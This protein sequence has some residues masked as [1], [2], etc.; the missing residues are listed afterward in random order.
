[1]KHFEAGRKRRVIYNDDSDQQYA[2]F[3]NHSIVDQQSFLNARTTPVFNTHV[4]TYVWC[5]GNG[6]DPP[7]RGEKVK[8]FLRTADDAT[9]VIVDSCREHGLE[10]WGS[11][12]MNDIHD[13]FSSDS[14]ENTND[15]LKAQ[16][17]EYLIAP[18]SA[19]DLPEELTE[20]S[21][22]TAFN[23]ARPEVRQYRLDFIERN[24]AAHDF[25]GY[26]LDFQRMPWFFPLGEERLHAGEMTELVREARSRLDA[27]GK[28]RG[29]AYTLVAHVMDS[30]ATSLEVGLD[31]ETWVS[32]GLLDVLVVGMGYLPYSV[33]LDQWLELGREYRVPVYPCVNTNTYGSWYRDVFKRNEAWHEAIRASSDYYLHRGADGLYIFNLFC[34]AEEEGGRLQ[35]SFVYA[36]LREIGELGTLARK[37]KLYSI[38][39]ITAGGWYYGCERGPLPIALDT[40]EHPL[41]LQM[42]S[43]A[44][45]PDARFTVL[46]QAT[47]PREG[48][49]VW[50]R[51]NHR[52]LPQPASDGPWYR[53]EV[54]SGVMR[55][56]HN[57]LSVWTDAELRSTDNPNI[58]HAVFV[59]TEYP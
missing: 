8:T 47:G 37:D 19:L 24:A 5:V 39:P 6:S 22:W 23:F 14:L 15:P 10:V 4:D 45:D 46:I 32:E 52:L 29:R 53:V 16:H 9:D 50:A 20:R 41:P 13:W 57:E 40:V 51:L 49:R 43:D 42:G 44:L 33:R 38:Q 12:R 30:I 2:E 36:P 59:Q 54:P 31:A 58:V 1:M 34:Q 7:W 25:D 26:E 56:G 27:V 35:K 21:L 48:R 3:T 28:R 55:P 18:R 11:L 17:P